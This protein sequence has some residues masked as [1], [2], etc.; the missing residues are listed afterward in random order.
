MRSFVDRPA[1]MLLVAIL[2]LAGAVGLGFHAQDAISGYRAIGSDGVT[3]VDGEL[4][5][6]Y[7]DIPDRASGARGWHWS[8]TV[9]ADTRDVSVHRPDDGALAKH[10]NE[11]VKVELN[12]GDVVAIRLGDGRLVRTTAGSA[13]GIV[14][15]IVGGLMLLC[16]VFVLAVAA[17]I[18]ARVRG[19]WWRRGSP[20]DIRRDTVPRPLANAAGV[21][22]A[23]AFLLFCF[24]IPYVIGLVWWG[25]VL[26]PVAVVGLV[27]G[28]GRVSR[29]RRSARSGRALHDDVNRFGPRP[30]RS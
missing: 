29:R 17:F 7:Q 18:T 19:G 30:G 21:G 14:R 13:Y 27:I 6:Y 2:A 20:G 22:L 8:V 16:V 1:V 26:V 3:V 23:A 5:G 24:F 10:N 4:R 11:S 12:G 25:S 15:D 28:L 9:G